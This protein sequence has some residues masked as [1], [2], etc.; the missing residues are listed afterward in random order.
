MPLLEPRVYLVRK[1]SKGLEIIVPFD[2]EKA[3]RLRW[4]GAQRNKSHACWAIKDPQTKQAAQ[5]LELYPTARFDGDSAKMAARYRRKV[6]EG[7]AEHYGEIGYAL[8]PTDASRPL[9]VADYRK[10]YGNRV[11][12]WLHAHGERPGE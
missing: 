2:A 8:S 12:D 7:R 1:T 5:L 3:C 10:K 9:S 6:A 11:I 4:I